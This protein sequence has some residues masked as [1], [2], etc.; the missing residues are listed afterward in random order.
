MLEKEREQSITD[1]SMDFCCSGGLF[2][3]FAKEVKKQCEMYVV[4][5]PW[6]FRRE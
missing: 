4:R 5:S 2:F 3:V 1:K 6:G